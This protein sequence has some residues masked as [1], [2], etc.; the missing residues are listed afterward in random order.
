MG[1]DQYKVQAKGPENSLESC[2]FQVVGNC[3]QSHKL[4][5]TF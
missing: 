4:L 2:I 3:V 5:I 1:G